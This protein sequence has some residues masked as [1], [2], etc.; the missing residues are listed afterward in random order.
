MQKFRSQTAIGWHM[1]HPNVTIQIYLF[2]I[3]K[4]HRADLYTG[5]IDVYVFLDIDFLCY[6]SNVT[7]LCVPTQ[8]EVNH[9]NTNL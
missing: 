2:I 9:V 7:I 3:I 1:R 6:V 4:P 8:F 5:V